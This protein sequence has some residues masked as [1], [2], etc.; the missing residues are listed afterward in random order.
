[1]TI[2]GAIF[3]CD[4]TL[5]DSMPMWNDVFPAWLTEHG[6]ANA[7]E[8]ADRYEYMNFTDECFF[9]HDSFG[10]CASREEALHEVSARVRDAYATRVKPFP[11]V[12]SFL[13]SLSAR[14][15]PMVIASSTTAELLRDA[16]S[17]HGLHMFFSDILYT[18]DVGA[19]KQH[20]DVYV[21]ARNSL[22]TATET[23]WVFEDA[24]FG[25][26]SAHDAGFP[27]VCLLNDHD[28]RDETFLRQHS[29]LLVHGYP[30]LSLALI[31]DY[32]RDTTDRQAI[33][34]THARQSTAAPSKQAPLKVLIAGGSPEKSS[35]QL[36]RRLAHDADYIIATDRGADILRE[37]G[38]SPH[39]L[40]GDDDTIDPE[41]LAW[42]KTCANTI[43]HFPPEKYETDLA[44]ALS[45][46]EHEARR[47]NK[48]LVLTLSCV[49][50]GRPDHL[51]GVM[52][53]LMAHIEAAPRI[54]ED[55]GNLSYECRLLS[56]KGVS[57]WQLGTEALHKTFSILALE[58]Q[59]V[60]SETGMRWELDH[61]RLSLLA[62]TGISNVVTREDATVTC[63]SGVL[64]CFLYD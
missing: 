59:S 37:A 17:V 46:A 30:E 38:V 28:G 33:P 41:T 39:V 22:G 16:L 25:V 9:F 58:P 2:T 36:I 4:G 63:H 34:H 14:G 40:C 45:C 55:A 7:R 54:V 43:I 27:T 12:R 44:I 35:P 3:D 11:G 10:I 21:A 52:G 60:A 31:N 56:P 32:E 53:N 26:Q 42:A 47:R 1:M 64:C 62:D 8:L 24:P 23:T 15:I 48:A 18:G 29:D 13:E 5:L 57:S 19:D 6:I 20:P 50:G 49:S 51:L 61:K